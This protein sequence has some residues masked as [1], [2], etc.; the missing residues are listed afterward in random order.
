MLIPFAR[1]LP[2]PW[3]FKY[4]LPSYSTSKSSWCILL[5]HIH[6]STCS[7]PFWNFFAQLARYLRGEHLI[8][9]SAFLT[10]QHSFGTMLGHVV[11]PEQGAHPLAPVSEKEKLPVHYSLGGLGAGNFT[12]DSCSVDQGRPDQMEKMNKV[13]GVAFPL[14]K[15]II[16]PLFLFQ[17][18]SPEG[19]WLLHNSQHMA[20]RPRRHKHNSSRSNST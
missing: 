18:K 5:P 3:P 19:E 9:K 20:F 1:M 17:I 12:A 4:S 14:H 6:P 16:C 13:K 2:L 8:Q 11:T 10:A 7:F 15:N